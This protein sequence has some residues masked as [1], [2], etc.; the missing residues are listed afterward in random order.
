MRVITGTA[1]G[2]RLKE[3]SGLET[4]PT[5]ALVKESLFNIVQFDL[6]GR[7][8]LDLFGGTGQLGIEALSRGAAHVTFVELRKEAVRLI[9]D[10]LAATKLQDRAT[11]LQ[12]DALAFLSRCRERYDLIF[13]D[14]P[15]DS[16]L[17]DQ[18]L[19]SVVGFDI[20]N[21]HGIIICESTA[22]KRMPVLP[23]PYEKGRD[24]RYGQIQLTAYSRQGSDPGT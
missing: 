24:Y 2:K 19:E 7:R 14:P 1:R 18:S 6:E 13:L 11:V 5:T 12:G 20:L 8:I 22:E 10:N 15:Y 9:R 23:A 3:L 17:L 21:E 4:R 16:K